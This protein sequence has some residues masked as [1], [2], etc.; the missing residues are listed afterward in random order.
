MRNMNYCII[1]PCYVFCGCD[2]TLIGSVCTLLNNEVF[3]PSQIV[4][5][6]AT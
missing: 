5:R 6:R 2:P 4:T 3:V 1:A